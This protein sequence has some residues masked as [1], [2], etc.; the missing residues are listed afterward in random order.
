M[1]IVTDSCCDLSQELLDRYDITMVPMSVSIANKVYVDFVE[2]DQ[3]KLFQLAQETGELPKTAAPTVAEYNK[4]FEG[5]DQV[6]CIT[7]SS[8]LSASYQNAM[9]AAEMLPQG[10]VIV[11]DSL[12]LSTGIGQLPIHAS[13]LR[14]AGM[15]V[16]AVADE[17]K[18][19]VPNMYSS[20]MIDT[21]EYLYKGGR[22]NAMQNIVGSM[23]KI[24]PVIKVQPDGTLNVHD[25]PRGARQRAFESLLKA[26]AD[27]LPKL[28][29]RRV[30]VTHTSSQEDAQYLASEVKRLAA[31]EE[32]L[33]T[34]AGSVISSHCGP[35]TIGILY[36]LNP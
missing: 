7:I 27:N 6:L 25:K 12:N 10:Q 5:D 23:L 1:K 17:I 20:F 22:C 3:V 35:N 31:P 30:F 14:S 28:D 29:R 4:A 11:I 33:I 36:H 18:S 21:F 26:L 9:L 15:K 8:R 13:E 19:W 32:V 16:E 24:H 2:M 34:R